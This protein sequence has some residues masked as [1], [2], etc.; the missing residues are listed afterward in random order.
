M[1]RTFDPFKCIPS[2]KA[3]RRRLEEIHEEARRLGVLLRTAE[4]IESGGD[5]GPETRHGGDGDVQ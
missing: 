1:A 3:V 4:E 2:A 5:D